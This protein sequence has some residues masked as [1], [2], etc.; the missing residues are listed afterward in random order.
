MNCETTYNPVQHL[1]RWQRVQA[2]AW[3]TYGVDA[4]MMIGSMVAGFI[5]G[6]ALVAMA[7]AQL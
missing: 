3:D 2:W 4:G 1:T 5:G 7:L 6:A